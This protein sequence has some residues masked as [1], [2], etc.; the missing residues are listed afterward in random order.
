MM[1][2]TLASEWLEWQIRRSRQKPFRRPFVGS[3]G[4]LHFDEPISLLDKTEIRNLIKNLDNERQLSKWPFFPFIRESR[5]QRKFKMPNEETDGPPIPL[6]TPARVNQK[7]YPHIK[8]RRL[9]AAAHRD[10]CLYSYY[11]FGLEKK[12]EA[13]LEQNKISENVLA[14]RSA[15]GKNNVEF[16]R[17]AFNHIIKSNGIT[18][19]LFDISGF[20]D[21]ISHKKL[22]SSVKEIAPEYTKG[23][24]NH[25]LNSL[26]KYRYINEDDIYKLLRSHKK[27]YIVSIPGGKSK[28]ICKLEDYKKI[29]ETTKNVRT[30][31]S[32]VGIPQGS[33]VSGL[34]ANVYLFNFDKDLVQMISGMKNG[35]Y[36]RYSD[37]ILIVCPTSEASK[38]YESCKEML[39]EN[40]LKIKPTKTEAF[41]Y[42]NGQ[43]TNTINSIE[44]TLENRPRDMQ[45]L[46]LHWDGTRIIL[47]PGTVVKRYRPSNPRR[48]QY[49]K[50]AIMAMEKIGQKAIRKQNVRIRRTVKR[51]IE[52]K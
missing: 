25:V 19:L 48:F 22:V 3:R 46:G 18:C 30:N 49:W 51:K 31:K 13:K 11:G 40:G 34:L 28:K 36:R 8:T 2:K 4:Y 15:L 21:A 44:P 26:T 45:Y 41:T 20:F 52:R 47:R 37:D 29:I 39:K 7:K 23:W 38:I 6:K 32:G 9:M 17:D 50:Y 1:T 24:R 43:L 27:K 35:Y 16:A 5:G 42:H 12:Y 14:Y 10:S 33:S